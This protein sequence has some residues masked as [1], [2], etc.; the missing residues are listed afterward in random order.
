[1]VIRFPDHQIGSR[2]KKD[3]SAKQHA[4]AASVIERRDFLKT[5]GAG[6]ALLTQRQLLFA[7]ELASVRKAETSPEESVNLGWP[8]LK[9]YDAT[10]LARIA[11]P[12]GGI[13]TGTVSLGGRGDLRDWELMNRPAKGFVPIGQAAPFFA[14]YLDRPNQAAIVR[15]LEGPLD[16]KDYEGS[17]GSPAPNHGL[18]R[19][20]Q[21]AFA[22]AY[23]L[24]QVRLADPD[25]PVEVRLEAFNPMIPG[26]ADAS[27]LPVA[28]L[29]Y[30]LH[31]TTD[32]PITAAVCGCV[33]NF[34][35]ID[36]WDQ[37][38]DWKGDFQS[39]GAK[40]N[41]NQ[42][43]TSSGLQ[44]LFM[45][46]E[47]VDR[48]APQW[49]TMAL[50]TTAKQPVSYRTQWPSRSWGG[51]LL[52]FWQDLSDDGS[53]QDSSAETMD[54]PMGSL[55]VKLL[56]PPHTTQSV[57]FLL[58]WHFPN[59]YDW[60]AP[61]ASAKRIGNYYTGQF[62]DAW[63][64][65]EKVAPR[66]AE[67]E[68]MTVKFVTAFCESDLPEE[69]KEAALFNLSTLRTQTCFRIEQGPLF[70]WEGCGDR[71]GCCHG[72]CTHVWNYEQATAFL[73]GSLA[74]TMRQVEFGHATDES[75]LMSFRAGLPLVDAKRFGKAAAD[76]QMGCIMKMYRD[77][78]LSGDDGQLRTLWPGVKK[79]LQFC[80]IPG[81]WDADRD[82]V[83]EGCQHNTMDVEYYGPNPQMGF[84]YLGALRAAAAM[85]VHV[86]D[87]DFATT[88]A[89]L[90][91][92]GREWIDRHLFNGEYYVQQI[93]LPK[94]PSEIA[95]SLRI[96]MGAQNIFSPDFQLGTGCLVDQLVGQ[97]MAHVCGLGYL[98]RPENIRCALA[99]ILKY[100]LR[101]GLHDHF[102]NMR[103]FVVG[104]E[105]ALL[106]ASFPK[107]RP[108]FPFPYFREAMTGFEYTAAIGLLYEGQHAGGLKCVR[109]IRARYDGK[110]RSPFDEAE[111][112]HHYARAMV[113]WAAVLAL[114]GF[115]YSA[116][117]KKITFASQ[118]GTF[119]WSNGYA[120]GTC[121]LKKREAA[122]AIRLSVLFGELSLRKLQL[123]DFGEHAFD[124]VE[125]VRA[126]GDIELE[127]AQV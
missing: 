30:A 38:R 56:L 76:G 31:N 81:G 73:Y 37:E 123:T 111:C 55:A 48:L 23:P 27:G 8:V 67:L 95:P 87:N 17:H 49:G 51:A 39:T 5:L 34:I 3:M 112:G 41:R 97:L 65:A 57:T 15:A 43:K 94:D 2:G 40:G 70:G 10:H 75:G 126:G 117:E 122:C 78:Q 86:G 14:L 25:L 107:D 7:D 24:G 64:V 60:S 125:T 52:D 13:G 59:R 72:S 42:F 104:D 102:N 96:G 47:G 63:D 66:L 21:C 101:S 110:K 113:S 50:V 82:G 120:W 12:I 118:D 74:M 20:R 22:A 89:R 4:T 92:Q 1:V 106:M 44:G 98:A 91:D 80:W 115:Q 68:N 33:P 84:W 45:D 16:P 109:N 127:I 108:P 32:K 71:K 29:R 121:R 53:A 79:A 85:A 19:F 116:V 100:N 6:T 9:Y 77:W 69:V 46:S 88:C 62:Q 58:C 36:G 124:G 103:S 119:F 54:M 83:M 99:S 26:D 61:S 11:M 28:V 35:G 105:N 18:P 93:R 114:T 90:G